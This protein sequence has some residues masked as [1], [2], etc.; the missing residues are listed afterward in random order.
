[1]RRRPRADGSD[2]LRATASPLGR[3]TRSRLRDGGA[4][5]PLPAAQIAITEGAPAF[6]VKARSRSSSARSTPVWA[7][8]LMIRSGARRSSVP[9]SVP[10]S[11]RFGTARS[12]GTTVP[13]LPSVAVSAL[14]TCR[15]TSV[16]TI[17]IKSGHRW[18][19][20]SASSGAAA[21]V[22]E[23][24]GLSIPQLMPMAGSFQRTTISSRAARL[25]EAA[26]AKSAEP[27]GKLRPNRW[28]K[29]V[30]RSR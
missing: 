13:S 14:P 15:V 27:S 18:E 10:G 24:E 20:L 6:T 9:G 23:R 29:S 5:F 4:E 21:S 3:R 26:A 8:G 19:G 17:R 11:A 1:M 16:R 25:Y 2:C 12:A 22:A 7:A 28:P 30:C